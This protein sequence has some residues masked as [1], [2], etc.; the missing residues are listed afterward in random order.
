[1]NVR[2]QINAALEASDAVTFGQRN[3]L[4]KQD[5]EDGKPAVFTR[6]GGES[7]LSGVLHPVVH[8]VALFAVA[9]AGDPYEGAQHAV[10]AVRSI[11]EE[12]DYVFVGATPAQLVEGLA[13]G[14]A[15][16][17]PY[18]AVLVPLIGTEPA[19]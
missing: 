14:D 8:V 6:W 12:V 16:K 15:G 11:F 5:I 17:Q 4:R 3:K 18:N 7:A 2:D 10:D 13:L 1:M 9:S 19:W